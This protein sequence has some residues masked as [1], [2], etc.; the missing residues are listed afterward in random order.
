MRCVVSL[1]WEQVTRWRLARGHLT[2]RVAEAKLEE[3]VVKICG[4]H[5]QIMS[6]VGLAM[7]ARVSGL[8]QARLERAMVTDRS[9]VKTWAMRGTLH[10]FAADDLPLYCAAQEP[11]DQAMNPSFLKNM[12]L[13]RADMEAILDAVPQ[14]LDGRELTREELADEV[15][16][17]TKKDHLGEPLRSGWGSCLKPAA[18]RG[19]LCFGTHKG[20]QVRFARPDQWIG[21]WKTWDPEDA[22]VET[23]RRFLAVYG[24]ADRAEIARWW[25]E[26]PP[27]AGRV[28]DRM[29]DELI[30]VGVEGGKRW[31]LER[32][33]RALRSAKP[34]TGVRLLPSFD[35]ILVMSAPHKQAIVDDEFK[36]RVYTAKPIAVWSLP[37]VLIDGRVQASWKLE[38]KTKRAVATVSPFTKLSRQSIDTLAEEV[39]K[40]GPVVGMPVELAM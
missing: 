12:G 14:A 15:V 2:R 24:P 33:L 5:A 3:A 20:T 38:R 9:L 17:L 16:R 34:V 28:L 39:E 32:D 8:N 13:E 21:G 11:R 29:T 26:R 30:E 27:V 1:T 23:F 10:V 4:A 37:A 6:T 22:V 18:F 25:G 7:A 40:L 19:L 35:E 31:M 36:V